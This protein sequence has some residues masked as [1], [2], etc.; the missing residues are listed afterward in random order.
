MRPTLPVLTLAASLALATPAAAQ[1]LSMGRGDG[2]IE[3]LADNGIEW[4]QNEQRFI[5]RGNAQ[6]MRG[7]VTLYADELIAYYE[8]TQ[9]T[10]TDDAAT[11]T[12]GPGS[13]SGGGDSEIS[14][15]EAHGNV[16]IVS[17]DE[18]AVGDDAFYQVD[19]GHLVMTGESLRLTT[20][21]EVLT[22][23]DRMTYDVPAKQ[24]V[25]EGNAVLVQDNGN[26][27]RARTLV[28]HFHEVEGK[29]E[30]STVDALED[31]VIVTDQETARGSQGNY[32][33]KTS[34]ATL[35]GS[36][37]LT[38]GDNVLT[39]AKAVTNM[40]TG[41]STLYGGG[42]AGKARAILTPKNEGDQ[43]DGQDTP[44]TQ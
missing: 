17:P 9:G 28:A 5:A 32:D 27:L 43:E 33:A 30:I 34:I 10:A 11:G 16:R 39:G 41:I 13:G 18:E 26:T 23:R 29:T 36:V 12:D 24:A 38:R 21:N 40:D 7:N 22:A 15:L 25:A 37:T 35:T 14:R 19:E 1:S 2:P 42:G 3:V 8:E 20:P 44:Q 6:A 31:V 4:R